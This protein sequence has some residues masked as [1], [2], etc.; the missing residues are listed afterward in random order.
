MT[1]LDL[2][3]TGVGPFL[4]DAS[5]MVWWSVDFQTASDDTAFLPCC[6]HCGDVF[7][8]GVVTDHMHRWVCVACVRLRD[9]STGDSHTFVRGIGVVVESKPP[10]LMEGKEACTTTM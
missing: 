9:A 10:W 3:R 1:K 4:L 7:F 5:G 6:E 8:E 2:V